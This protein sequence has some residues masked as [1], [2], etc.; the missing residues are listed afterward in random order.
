MILEIVR[1]TLAGIEAGF[2][3]GVSNVASH[4]DCTLEVDAS[5]YRI[6]GKFLANSVDALVEVDF[7]ALGTLTRTAKLLRNQ[8]GWV[9]VEFFNP[10]TVLVNLALDVAVGRTAYTHTDWA[11]CT[12]TRQANHANI[13]SQIFATELCAQTYLICLLKQLV[14]EVDIAECTAGFVAGGRQIVVV[15]NAG[16]LHC[17]QILFSRSAANHKCDVIRRTSCSAQ[18]LHLFNQERKQSALVLNSSLGHRVEISL[19]G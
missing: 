12:V 13:V 2:Q 18:S 10:H 9:G 3:L 11:A 14:F 17:E 6:F 15:L 7:D 16:K 5:R 1:H 4:N 19:V 8:F